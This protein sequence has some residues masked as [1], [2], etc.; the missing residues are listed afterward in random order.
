MRCLYCGKPLPLLKKLT[1]GGEFCSDAH[2]HKYQEEYNKLALSRLLQAQTGL[3]ESGG[4]G[5][6]GSGGGGFR[7]LTAPTPPP[8]LALRALAP[9]ALPAPPANKLEN[10]PEPPPPVAA[11]T[12][13]PAPPPPPDPQEANFLVRKHAPLPPEGSPGFKKVEL[14]F[15]FEPPKPEVWSHSPDLGFLPFEWAA[16]VPVEAAASAL[17]DPPDAPAWRHPQ[18][19]RVPT[20]PRPASEAM[21]SVES[22]AVVAMFPR[23]GQVSLAP[24]FPLQARDKIRMDATLVFRQRPG[25]LRLTGVRDWELKLSAPVWRPDFT[26]IAAPARTL[27]PASKPPAD[28]ARLTEK[29]IQAKLRQRTPVSQ[30]RE[31]QQPVARDSADKV[32]VFI[33]LS[34]FGILDQR[35]ERHK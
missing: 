5:L 22:F 6:P 10:R 19:I 4:S 3:G 21:A 31:M 24:R 25:E 14:A 34:A 28:E 26:T 16:V 17:P 15:E 13:A 11:R 33:D 20:E 9:P 32:E 1:G 18:E 29:P 12:L 30:V 2:R 8:P 35:T 27:I 7:Q 23:M